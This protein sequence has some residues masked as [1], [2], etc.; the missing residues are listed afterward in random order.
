MP[1]RKTLRLRRIFTP[2]PNRGDGQSRAGVSPAAFK[3]R[4]RRLYVGG[5]VILLQNWRKYSTIGVGR[6]FRLP[7]P[8]NR[9]GGSPASGSPVGGS[10]FQGLT[11]Q[12]TP[13]T[14]VSR[15]VN[16]RSVQTAGSTH[17]HRARMSPACIALADTCAGCVSRRMSFTLPPPCAA[18]APRALPRFIATM[19]AL[20]PV[21]LALR[22]LGA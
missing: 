16:M 15:A 1:F 22:R 4:P 14:P 11:V 2:L 6:A 17:T 13:F 12:G 18:F 5:A 3:R 21:R 8:P 19:R 7:L 9:T 10:P 20:T